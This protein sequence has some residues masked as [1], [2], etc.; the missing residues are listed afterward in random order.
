MLL[1]ETRVDFRQVPE[2]LSFPNLLGD[3]DVCVATANNV[4]EDSAP[5]QAGG[6]ASVLMA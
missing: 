4:T 1:Q 2:E 6:V 5:Y 3:L